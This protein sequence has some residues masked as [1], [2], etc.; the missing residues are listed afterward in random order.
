MCGICGLVAPHGAPDP[1]LVERM[2]DAIRH[3]GPDDGGATPLGRACLGHRRLAVVD[4][5][6]GFQP[7]A[8]EDGGITVVFNGEVY[9]FAALHAELE[10]KGH[11]IRGHGDTALLPH[12]YEEHGPRFI[13]RLHG[14][15]ALA[16]WD[17]GRER[18]VL[19]RDRV[20]KKPLLYTTLPD[21]TF[22]FASEL[23]ALLQLPGVRR[24][25]DPEQVDAFLAL[26]YVP[27]DRSRSEERRVG[28]EC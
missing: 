2:A 16:L 15:F 4:L 22:A 13:E 6:Q 14:M 17:A 27:G 18:L 28:K 8:S 23:K 25:V 12:L 9:D 7:A 1:A 26:Q 20:G 3:R 5:Q 24:A 10:A 11:A 21:G 19:A